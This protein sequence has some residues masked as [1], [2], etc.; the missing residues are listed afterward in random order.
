MNA[1]L[2]MNRH[3]STLHETSYERL[4][5]LHPSEAYFTNAGAG[6]SNKQFPD[7]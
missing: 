7:R 3:E 4:V 6:D 2:I 5:M 1:G